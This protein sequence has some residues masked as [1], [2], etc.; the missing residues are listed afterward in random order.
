[1]IQWRVAVIKKILASAIVLSVIPI[2]MYW[3]YLD[4]NV[5]EKLYFTFEEGE[6]EY[7]LCGSGKSKERIYIKLLGKKEEVFFNIYGNSKSDFLPCDE[8]I[9][10][11]GR[12]LRVVIGRTNSGFSYLE[13]DGY[14]VNSEADVQAKYKSSPD[15]FFR[16]FLIVAVA[17]FITLMLMVKVQYRKNDK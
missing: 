12:G 9:V 3:H 17:C 4:L 5:R 14:V 8:I 2:M 11:E 7:I 13:V 10:N 1:M 6:A 16:A 15:D